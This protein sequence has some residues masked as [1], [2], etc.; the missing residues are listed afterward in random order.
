MDYGYGNRVLLN[1]FRQAIKIGDT[2]IKRQ[3]EAE[4]SWEKDLLETD[5]IRKQTGASH[6]YCPTDKV[7]KSLTFLLEI[8][9]SVQDW[10]G[11]RV[12]KQE[13]SQIRLDEAP[14]ALIIKGTIKFENYEAD[15]KDVIGAFNR[16]ERFVQI[17]P[18]AVGLFSLEREFG[19]LQEIAEEGELVGETIRVKKNRFGSLSGLFEK[20][21]LTPSLKNFNEKIQN[22]T[23]IEEALPSRG[24]FRKFA[25]LSTARFKLA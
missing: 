21:E 4:K 24:V 19:Y 12:I 18:D 13:S 16:R 8:G 15:V 14:N 7:A 11:N 6:Y 2:L 5:F 25:P 17:A 9:W 20:A 3:L 10:K 22:F 23:G 1:D